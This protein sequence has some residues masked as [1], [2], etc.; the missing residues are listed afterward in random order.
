MI[1]E[2]GGEERNLVPKS[3]VAPGLA[4]CAKAPVTLKLNS[5]PTAQ[6]LPRLALN[7]SDSWLSGRSAKPLMEFSFYAYN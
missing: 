2:P 6:N 3:I 4:A 7:I 1:T 5:A